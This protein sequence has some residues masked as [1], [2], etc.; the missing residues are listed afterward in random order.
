MDAYC[1]NAECRVVLFTTKTV[2]PEREAESQ[3]CPG[4][5]QFGRL[6]DEK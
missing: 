4:C 2:G 3:N 5:G 1:E 6:K